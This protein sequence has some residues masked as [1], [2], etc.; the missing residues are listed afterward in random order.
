MAADE[1]RGRTLGFL[2]VGGLASFVIEGLRRSGDDRPI[3]LSPRGARRSAELAGR[4]GCDVAL[5]NQSV[6]DGADMVIVSTPPKEVLACVA[7]VRWRPGQRLVCV[8]ID[9]TLAALV[10]AAPGARVLRA[11]PSASAALCMGSTPLYPPDPVASALLERLGEVHQL[12]DEEAFDAATA[13][14]GYHLWCFGLM[15][16]VAEAA[17]ER[18]L[19]RAAAIGMVAGLSR[20]A[21]ELAARTAPG[22]SMRHALDEHGTPDT[23]TAQGFAVIESFGGLEAWRR[24]YET[25]VARLKTTSAAASGDGASPLS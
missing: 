7:A 8:A 21:A 23:M 5:D 13:L 14:A 19:P 12:P 6:V 25:A 10:E 9:V 4:Y 2:G 11:M 24:A 22:Q 20:S 18:G 15:H 3:L 1:S 16:A 17:V